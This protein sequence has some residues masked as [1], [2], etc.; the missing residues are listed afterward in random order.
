MKLQLCWPF[1]LHPTRDFRWRV[2]VRA[3]PGPGAVPPRG[4]TQGGAG[5]GQ[6]HACAAYSSLLSL[7]SLETHWRLSQ[8]SRNTIGM[9]ECS[10]FLP[11]LSLLFRNSPFQSRCPQTSFFFVSTVIPG[12]TEGRVYPAAG[13]FS[14]PFP[15]LCPSY[16][17]IGS[18]KTSHW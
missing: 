2:C 9:G 7:H 1:F 11:V 13:F 16:A 15:G 12:G 6:A 8:C 3:A 18:S 17:G 5:D 10:A 14:S 4:S